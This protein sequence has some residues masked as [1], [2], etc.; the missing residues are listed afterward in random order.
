MKTIIDDKVLNAKFDSLKL[1]LLKLFRFMV[2]YR[3]VYMA[4]FMPKFKLKS[5][6]MSM[7]SIAMFFV[8]MI[9][10]SSCQNLRP[11]QNPIVQLDHVHDFGAIKISFSPSGHLLASGG[12]GGEIKIWQVPSGKF[13]TRLK[14]HT[15]PIKGLQWINE[16]TLISA[17]SRGEIIKWNLDSKQVIKRAQ[18][19]ALTSLIYSRT[20]NTFYTGHKSGQLVEWSV[21]SLSRKMSRQF[22]SKIFSVAVNRIN[23]DVAI[24]TK[25]R[26]V[27]LLTPD[28]TTKAQF[29]S[30]KAKLFEL[31]FSAS[32]EKLGGS[33]WF[34]IYIWNLK[35]KELSIKNT[36]H[37]GA[38]VSFDFH[39]VS[40]DIISLGRHTDAN[41]RLMNSQTAE[42]KRR[43]AAHEYC[44]WNIRFSPTGKYVAS[45]SED[46]S[47]RLYNMH[48]KYNPQW[49][50]RIKQSRKTHNNLS[51]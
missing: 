2:V 15:K 45:A 22:D 26:K 25:S 16:S 44:G 50:K 14:S 13:L 12:F 4:G 24:S 31:R 51:D 36:E 9:S 28:L 33:S 32:G 17:S 27:I 19:S 35:S 11:S 29:S 5:K 42:V 34:K 41:I 47:I 21:E 37:R 10:L 49:S 18:S 43:L 7:F 6:L 3:S 40:N 8:V 23:G 39:P 46:E 38:I 30:N 20:Q 48:E 1:T